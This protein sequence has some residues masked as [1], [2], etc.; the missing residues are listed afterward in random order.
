MPRGWPNG[1]PLKGLEPDGAD[2][3]DTR[4]GG[5]R[6]RRPDGRGGHARGAPVFPTDRS[7]LATAPRLCLFLAGCKRISISRNY[8]NPSRTGSSRDTHTAPA[9]SSSCISKKWAAV[10]SQPHRGA[11]L[12]LLFLPPSA[13]RGNHHRRRSGCSPPRSIHLEGLK[14][15]AK[16]EPRPPGACPRH[17][18]EP[19]H[20]AS[21]LGEIVRTLV[22]ERKK[23]E[24][25]VPTL[26]K[27]A[28]RLEMRGPARTTMPEA[29]IAE[30]RELTDDDRLLRR[31]GTARRPSGLV[32]VDDAGQSRSP[33]LIGKSGGE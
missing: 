17:R 28:A 2:L 26:T 27:P 16:L 23:R 7:P 14:D 10:G 5:R 9:G 32:S 33:G 21:D 11:D 29:R 3:L 20:H 13:E 1:S 6:L 18:R 8:G 30:L 19:F 22:A 31:D 25:D 15:A 4:A 12:A 24:I